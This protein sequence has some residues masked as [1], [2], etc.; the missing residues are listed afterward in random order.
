MANL[1][2]DAYGGTESTTSEAILVASLSV[3]E[4]YS[5]SEAYPYCLVSPDQPL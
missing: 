4:G 5:A 1:E 3:G 2:P